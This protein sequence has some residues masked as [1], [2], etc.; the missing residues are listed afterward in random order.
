MIASDE[1][2]NVL[3]PIEGHDDPHVMGEDKVLAS[4]S[5]KE[6]LKRF[7]EMLLADAVE[8]PPGFETNLNEELYINK[9]MKKQRRCWFQQK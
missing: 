5:N 1:Y 8:R 7:E 6:L 4:R 2:S 9:L 3:P